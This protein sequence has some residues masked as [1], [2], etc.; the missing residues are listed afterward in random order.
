[1]REEQRE[2]EW[3]PAQC[4]WPATDYA[5]KR[6]GDH[7]ADAE[8]AWFRDESIGSAPDRADH[9]RLLKA[10]RMLA[11]AP[12]PA[13]VDALTCAPV[14]TEALSGLLLLPASLRLLRRGP[15]RRPASGDLAADALS[16]QRTV[17]STVAR[18]RACSDGCNSTQLLSARCC[19]SLRRGGLRELFQLFGGG[20]CQPLL[21]FQPWLLFQLLL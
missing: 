11:D 21:L 9:E 4:G 20:L 10:L 8:S 2:P 14:D 13:V 7:A 3:P 5:G 18:Q 12:M 19:M 6:R 16:G 1:V 17:D 15:A